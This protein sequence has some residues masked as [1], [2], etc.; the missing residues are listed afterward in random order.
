MAVINGLPFIQTFRAFSKVVSSCF[1]V[2]L[3]EDYEV[4]ILEFRRLYLELGISVTPKVLKLSTTF[5]RDFTFGPYF[6]K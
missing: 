2:S 5:C 1:G 4:H 6:H 3:Q